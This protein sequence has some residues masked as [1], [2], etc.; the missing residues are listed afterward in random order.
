MRQST[1]QGTLR[2]TC[3]QPM[4]FIFVSCGRW[5]TGCGIL[6][7]LIF[8]FE[9]TASIHSLVVPSSLH[10]HSLLSASLTRTSSHNLLRETGSD[11]GPVWYI[12]N[13]WSLHD[14]W[15]AKGLVSVKHL[16]TMPPP[17]LERRCPSLKC[18]FRWSQHLIWYPNVDLI[19]WKRCK[20]GSRAVYL[21]D[22]YMYPP[23]CI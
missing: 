21:C 14:V 3:A 20:V 13:V 12:L 1:G 5:W 23:T 11:R 10:H 6:H 17:R 4:R 19:V 15:R 8:R 16:F 9:I 7:R 2:R 18:S 22:K